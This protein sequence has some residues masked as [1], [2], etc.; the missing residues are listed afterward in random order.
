[1]FICLS[2]FSGWWLH[3]SLE[4]QR[5]TAAEPRLNLQAEEAPSVLHPVIRF[6][7]AY[8]WWELCHLFPGRRRAPVHTPLLLPCSWSAD[9]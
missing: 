3:E 9:M 7:Q 8:N 1:M 5:C 6:Y 2:V 4:T